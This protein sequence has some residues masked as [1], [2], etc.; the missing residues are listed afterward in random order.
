VRAL[1]AERRAQH[2]DNRR[3]VPMLCLGCRSD[4]SGGRYLLERAR[5]AYQQLRGL[6]AIYR[7][8]CRQLRTER[9]SAPLGALLLTGGLARV[10]RGTGWL[11]RFVKRCLWRAVDSQLQYVRPS[12]VPSRIEAML[13]RHYFL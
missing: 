13:R 5:Q 1:N 6:T 10:H 3:D 2:H 12:V 7:Q 4:Q 8:D 9:L 11:A